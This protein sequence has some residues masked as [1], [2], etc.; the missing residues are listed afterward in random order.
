MT[1]SLFRIILTVAFLLTVSISSVASAASILLVPTS[2]IINVRA[3]DL[4]T[5][6]VVMD[7]SGDTNG[8]GSDITLGGGFDIIFDSSQLQFQSLTNANIGDFANRDPDIFDGLLESWSFAS[9]D[10]LTGPA[11]V[12]SVDFFVLASGVPGSSIVSTGPT[13]GVGGP[14]VSGVDFVTILNVDYN[15]IR[16]TS[17][18]EPASALFILIGLGILSRSGRSR[19]R[20]LT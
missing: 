7:F 16:V 19:A 6:D 8:L 13:S 12:G 1:K 4:V 17:V 18:P 10:G 15:S 2:P 14:F 3:S 11:L 9:F 5:F 20:D